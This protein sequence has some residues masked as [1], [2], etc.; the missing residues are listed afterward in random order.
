[1]VPTYYLY[2]TCN[3]LDIHKVIKFVRSFVVMSSLDLETEQTEQIRIP[4]EWND[5][6]SFTQ[7]TLIA[8][9]AQVCQSCPIP[10]HQ[11]HAISP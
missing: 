10:F 9:S 4:V 7:A 6:I 5:Q 1:M 8:F 2:F 11:G 3:L